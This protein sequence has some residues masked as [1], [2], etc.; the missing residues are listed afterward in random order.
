MRYH[1]PNCRRLLHVPDEAVNRLARCPACGHTSDA[2]SERDRLDEVVSG[3]LAEDAEAASRLVQSA[4]AARF[5]QR[6]A[7]A[8]IGATG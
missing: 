5:R 3:W 7:A 6:T 1:C 8:A 4:I 2:R